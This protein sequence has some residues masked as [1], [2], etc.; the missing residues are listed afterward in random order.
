M[1][2][3]PLMNVA[4]RKETKKLG[5]INSMTTST[6]EEEE[7]FFP[8]IFPKQNQQKACPTSFCF[9][10]HDNCFNKNDCS[11]GKKKN[12]GRD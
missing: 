3:L 10:F 4:F 7:D 11:D 12:V 2:L 6:G 9:F 8:C 1:R 5:K